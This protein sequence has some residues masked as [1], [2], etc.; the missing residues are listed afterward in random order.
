MK[1]I[2]LATDFSP[3]ALNAARYAADLAIATKAELVLFHVYDLTMLFL[4]VPLPITTEQMQTDSEEEL[5]QLRM[6]L[7]RQSGI[8]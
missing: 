6:E 7:L 2:L 4:Q 3:A 8:A 5:S 1:R